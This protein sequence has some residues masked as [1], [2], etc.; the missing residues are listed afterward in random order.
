VAT[1]LA[2]TRRLL[3]NS[4]GI[5][6]WLNKQLNDAKRGQTIDAAREVVASKKLSSTDLLHQPYSATTTSVAP[7]RGPSVPAAVHQSATST[8]SRPSHSTATV[9]GTSSPLRTR[10]PLGVKSVNVEANRKVHYARGDGS[11]FTDGKI[12]SKYVFDPSKAPLVFLPQTLCVCVCV[13]VCVCMCVCVCLCARVRA[14]GG[15]ISGCSVALFCV[16]KFVIRTHS[17]V[18]FRLQ[19]RNDTRYFAPAEPSTTDDVAESGGGKS[20]LPRAA[21]ATKTISASDDAPSMTTAQ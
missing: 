9:R 8:T 13:C 7:S 2:E 3:K 17:L 1:E 4:E 16:R 21:T 5:I 18:G 11:N 12:P 6:T 19:T 10:A 14:G 20:R 15:Q